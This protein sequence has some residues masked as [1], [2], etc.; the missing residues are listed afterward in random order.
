MHVTQR[1]Y[2]RELATFRGRGP[3]SSVDL[4]VGYPNYVS[5]MR[6]M[7]LSCAWAPWPIA[8]SVLPYSRCQGLYGALP[9][10]HATMQVWAEISIEISPFTDTTGRSRYVSL[11]EEHGMLLLSTLP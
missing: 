6:I 7:C 10:V 4:L 8:E 5:Y 9:L 1:R 11:E 2:E 3:D